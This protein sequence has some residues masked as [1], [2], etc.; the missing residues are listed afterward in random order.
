GLPITGPE[1]GDT[2]CDQPAGNPAPATLEWQQRDLMNMVCSAQRLSDQYANPDFHLALSARGSPRTYTY[3]LAEQASDP[4]RP[5]ATLGQWIPGGR[6]TDPY[7]VDEDWEFVGRGRVDHISFIAESGARLVGRVFRPPSTVPGPY[8]LIV[9]TTGSIQGY[10]EMYNWAAEGLAEAGYLVLSYDVQGQGRSET[11]PHDSGGAPSDSGQGV[12]FQQAYNFVQGTKDALRWALSSASSPYIAPSANT[13]GTEHYN[14]FSAE[15]DRSAIG[16]AGH[17]LGASAVSQVAQEQACEPSLPRALRDGCVSAV[18]GWD[19][20]SAP[21]GI[22]LKAPGLS[23]TAEYFFNPTPT[24]SPP[25]ADSGMGAFNALKGAGI[26]SMRVSLRSSTHL[27]WTYIPLILPASRYGERVSMHYTLAWFDRYVRDQAAATQRLTATHFDTSADAS[28]IGAGT[29]DPVSGNNVPY[30]INGRCV[31]NHVSI[32]NRS[33]YWLNGGAREAVNLRARGCEADADDD[34]VT[35]AQ[36]RCPIT[37]AGEAVDASGCSAAQAAADDDDDGVNNPA[38]ACPATPAGEAV[39]ADGC[40]ATQRDSDGDGVNDA[41][42]QCPATPTGVEVDEDGCPTEATGADYGSGLIGA[43]A[44][45]MARLHGVVVALVS[46]DVQGAGEL[47]VA[48]VTEF[49]DNVSGL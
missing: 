26:D 41:A 31:A 47:L 32:Y 34:G 10:Q 20:L 9:I 7:R 49:V 21:A 3:N 33:A 29:Y 46:G 30:R 13:A 40:S 45:Y 6:S 25:P 16:L 5:R 22:P 2:A 12:P 44:Q 48:A 36:D 24:N 11:L 37:P 15:V 28:S 4:T 38:D 43:I 35:G 19:A 18:V 17:S 1:A 42:D 8:P 27:E 23:L 14:P 39:D